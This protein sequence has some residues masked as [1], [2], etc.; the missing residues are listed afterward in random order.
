MQEITIKINQTRGTCRIVNPLYLGGNPTIVF[1]PDGAYSVVLTEPFAD[2]PHDGIKVWAQSQENKLP[3]NRKALHD[4]FLASHARQPN[5]TLQAKVYILNGDNKTIADGDVTIE[6]SPA[7]YIV[8]TATYPT[9]QEVL[10]SVIQNKEETARYTKEANT[11]K[12]EAQTAATKA[13]AA[14][15]KSEQILTSTADNLTLSKRYATDAAT[16]ATAAALAKEEAKGYAQKAAE[17]LATG[18]GLIKANISAERERAEN[19]E[20]ELSSRI[21]TIVGSDKD[22]SA[23]AIASEEV[24]KLINGAPETFDTFKEVAEYIATDK[25]G[26]AAMAAS[27]AANKTAISTNTTAI[28]EEAERAKAEEK[29][30][31]TAIVNAQKTADEAKEGLDSKADKS[32][33]EAVGDVAS[34]AYALAEATNENLDSIRGEVDE[35]NRKGDDNTT[36]INSINERLGEEE[37]DKP[38]ILRKYSFEVGGAGIPPDIDE[39]TID[40]NPFGNTQVKASYYPPDQKVIVRVKADVTG[41]MRDAVLSIACDDMPMNIGWDNT[42]TWYP[43][44]DLDTDMGC[45]ANAENIYFITEFAPNEF[46]VSRW[47]KG[48]PRK[49]ASV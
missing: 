31:S 49:E 47:V 30:I 34:S 25:T 5:S 8:D 10:T 3:L 2:S 7:L 45:D 14:T 22:K 20:S 26:A 16:Q 28:S 33:L 37:L 41:K 32:E 36:S 48:E 11:A 17:H 24:S 9:I 46:L 18:E 4:A 44:T 6:Y 29:K 42:V 43:R 27:I 38:N 39:Y 23:R 35:A 19:A 12:E 1:E 13:T 15:N 21:D 40:I